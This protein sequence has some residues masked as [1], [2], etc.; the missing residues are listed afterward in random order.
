MHGSFL[1]EIIYLLLAAVIFVPI[2]QAIKLGAVPGFLLAGILIGPGVLGL[3]HDVENIAH[4]SEFGVVLLLFVIGME[5]KPAFL[6]RIR[7]LVFGLGSAQI[8]ICTALITSLCYFLLE[9]SWPTAIVI[10]TALSLSSTA[11]VLQILTDKKQLTTETGKPSVAILLMQDL[12]V[13]PLLALIP[14][15]A[16]TDSVSSSVGSAFLQSVGILVA[17]FLGGRYLLTPLLHRV[18]L[19]A[20]AEVFTALAVLIVLGTAY[21]TELAGLSMAMGAFLAGLLISDSAYRHQIKA[22]IQ[23]FRGLLLGAFFVAMGM[24]LNISGLINNPSI[25][26]FATLG[27]IAIKVAV[28]TPLARLFGLSWYKALSVGLLLGQGG[29]F[30]LVLFTLAFNQ[31]ILSQAVF[32]NL[33]L[34]VLVSM[35]VTP[36]LA[37][38]S[39][40]LTQKQKVDS[41]LNT[42]NAQQTEGKVVIAGFGRVGRAVSNV[43]ESANISYMAFDKSA[44]IV[45]AHQHEH[46]IFFGDVTQTSLLHAGGIQHASCVIITVNSPDDAKELVSTL[47]HAH[48]SLPLYVRGHNVETCQ[49]LY[50][51]GATKVISENIEVSL[52]LSEQVLEDQGIDSLLQN[53]LL[54]AFRENYYKKIK[55]PTD[56]IMN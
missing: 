39:D 28:I 35:L 11:F 8:L 54:T 52:E 41:E 53:Q 23:P 22:E 20:N 2:A 47:H 34:V 37:Y 10:G 56:T 36:V 25:I 3:V 50:Q 51:L 46:P 7:H 55:D 16:A 33:M 26:V 18:A 45:K 14:M 9:L 40:V 6:W 19:S 48:P 38:F 24:S 13:V 27:L 31:S 21:L 30:A 42:A 4:I 49:A 17:V 29:E 1:L 32:D 5:M 12:A 43:L 15:L 44:K